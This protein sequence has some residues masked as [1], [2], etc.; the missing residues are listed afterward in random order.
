MTSGQ[1]ADPD[2]R[3]SYQHRNSVLYDAVY[4]QHEDIVKILLDFE[5][6][7]DCRD[8][9]DDEHRTAL[10]WAGFH[11]SEGIIR[12][13]VDHDTDIHTPGPYGWTPRYWAIT[14]GNE[15]M[16][17]LLNLICKPDNCA[18]CA[19]AER[20][21]RAELRRHEESRSDPPEPWISPSVS[22][23]EEIRESVKSRISSKQYGHITTSSVPRRQSYIAR[24]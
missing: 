5:Y 11:G 18:R 15:N 23:M 1:P 12:M 9:H 4:R 8:E 19:K 20:D 2:T 7:S 24:I 6:F 14:N 3:S 17:D 21:A 10:Y 16:L 13:L 22:V